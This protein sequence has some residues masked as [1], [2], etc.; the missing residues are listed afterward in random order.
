M[1]LASYID[2]DFS[3]SFPLY[4]F[5]FFEKKNIERYNSNRNHKMHGYKLSCNET[6]Y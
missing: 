1:Y 4:I 6:L 2:V 5:H 3:T